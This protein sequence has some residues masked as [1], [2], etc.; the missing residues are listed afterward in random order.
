MKTRIIA[1]LALLSILFSCTA[2]A[3]LTDLIF[4][5]NSTGTVE[6]ETT[7]QQPSENKTITVTFKNSDDSVIGETVVPYGDC[8]SEPMFPEIAGY[9]FEG[10]FLNLS[11]DTPFDFS[12][13]I[14]DD[15]T[16]YAKWSGDDVPPAVDVTLPT[17][18]VEY[19]VTALS[20]DPISKKATVSATIANDCKILVRFIE[21]EVYFSDDFHTNKQYIAFC[22]AQ[23][24]LTLT[25]DESNVLV[26]AEITGALPTHFVAEAVLTDAD[27][28]LLSKEFSDISHTT[29]Y[30]AFQSKTVDDFGEDAKILI[31]DDSK[32][33]NF[34][35]LADDVK[36]LNAKS[37]NEVA[38][39]DEDGLIYWIES[40][41]ETI[42][43]GEKL[44][45][46]SESTEVLIKVGSVTQ[47]SNTFS[48]VP[49][50]ADGENG[51]ALMDF[52]KFLKVDMRFEDSE[53]QLASNGQPL[54]IAAQ[55]SEKKWTDF[56]HPVRFSVAE[57]V[58]FDGT[59][60]GKILPDK[61]K[62]NY[63]EDTL[64]KEYLECALSYKLDIFLK[65][66]IK[67]SVGAKP[68]EIDVNEVCDL[69]EIPLPVMFAG[70]NPKVEIGALLSWD[71]SSE[72]TLEVS[73]KR[74]VGF[75]Y[76]SKTGLTLINQGEKT[77]PPKV[78]TQGNAKIKIGPAIGFGVNF[79]HKVAEA[80]VT[81]SG[82]VEAIV[83]TKHAIVDNESYIIGHLC[84]RCF[85]CEI[86]RFVRIEAGLEFGRNPFFTY[87]PVE[88]PSFDRTYPITSYFM[89]HPEKLD[90][91]W[92]DY[93]AFLPAD[94]ERLNLVEV[95]DGYY[96]G[97]GHC[98]F[99]IVYM[100]YI[101][102]CTEY[103]ESV[104][105]CGIEDC[106]KTHILCDYSDRV[107]CN[108]EHLH[109]DDSH[110]QKKLEISVYD[111]VSGRS[112]SRIFEKYYNIFEP[113]AKNWTREPQYGSVLLSPGN[114]T[115]TVTYMCEHYC[116]PNE[117]MEGDEH[118]DNLQHTKTFH[119]NLQ[120][121]YYK[122]SNGELHVTTVD[123]E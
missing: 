35:V 32:T 61:A 7:G 95:G 13:T 117:N 4:F 59:M 22:E 56:I 33:T 90:S 83:S 70:L 3:E 108:D 8:I 44:C 77:D 99:Y 102:G 47:N 34:G 49:E 105:P 45:V 58:E 2:C 31:F 96:M 103:L 80:K 114:Y 53:A 98:P 111:A 30:E 16:L 23:G 52:Y 62:F 9:T 116:D 36:I 97:Q 37:I 92:S 73:V 71:V 12:E 24:N 54:N 109:Y 86:N 65:G 112:R 51:Y 107:H 17:E 94:T 20:I 115:I 67:V 76:S 69:L 121:K 6:N 87:A 50:S 120:L 11:D 123:L 74:T 38:L 78:E 55:K 104:C 68:E 19:Q 26:E 57:K 14:E 110:Y 100:D 18:D 81:F 89:A 84:D 88:I 10:W 43:A 79:L 41:S 66:T 122:D 64:G 29:R 5:D 118:V 21:E 75:D 28:N 27:G 82:G 60:S 106:K 63:D 40:P 85:T 72:V 93:W 113:W 46:K 25:E 101:D 1:I 48:V 15:I 119:K 39:G 42:A 91:S